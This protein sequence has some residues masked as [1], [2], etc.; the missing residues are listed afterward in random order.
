[1]MTVLNKIILNQVHRKTCRRLPPNAK[2]FLQIIT[3]VTTK[4]GEP[5]PEPEPFVMPNVQDMFLFNTK[6]EGRE[7]EHDEMEIQEQMAM[8]NGLLQKY[9]RVGAKCKD[10]VRPVREYLMRHL[11]MLQSMMKNMKATGCGVKGGCHK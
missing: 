9:E 2:N 5:F 10:K 11:G 3:S 8:I 4:T 1:M 7:L 6:W